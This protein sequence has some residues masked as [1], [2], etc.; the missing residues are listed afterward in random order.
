MKKTQS[1]IF[2]R[3]EFSDE[4]GL[5]EGGDVFQFASMSDVEEMTQKILKVAKA[6]EVAVNLTIGLEGPFF[7][8]L[9]KVGMTRQDVEE[10]MADLALAPVASQKKKMTKK[11]AVKKAPAK[12]AT[13]KKSTKTKKK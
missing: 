12:K 9:E 7:G 10:E 13:A 2:F 6:D 8:F 4:A 5:P 3:Y 11:K 1:P